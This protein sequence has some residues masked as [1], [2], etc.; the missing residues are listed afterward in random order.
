MKI[1]LQ[2]FQS[3]LVCLSYI[4][5]RDKHLICYADNNLNSSIYLIRFAND[6]N[7][8]Y[9][10]VYLTPHKSVKKMLESEGISCEMH[11]SLKGIFHAFRANI[12]VIS[13]SKGQ[14]NSKLSRHAKIIN[15]WHGISIKNIGALEFKNEK[16]RRQKLEKYASFRYVPSTSPFTQSCFMKAFGKNENQTP[17]L[18]E[19]RNDLLVRTIK[20]TDRTKL[21]KYVDVDLASISK[22]ISYMPTWRDYGDWDSN[23]DFRILNEKMINANALFL[24]KPHPKDK[25]LN[26]IKEFSN[27]RVVRRNDD[28]Q[29]AYEILIAT[30]ILITDYSSLAYEFI[31]TRRPI[32]LYTPDLENFRSQRDFW[33]DFL[34]MAPSEPITDLGKLIPQIIQLLEH[35]EVDERYL[36]TLDL[37]HSVQDGTSSQRVYDLIKSIS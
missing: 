11:K 10:H 12:Y 30:D 27:V 16:H 29:D 28:W 37:L 21:S 26:S 15:L 34:E 17:I 24:V 35:P 22:I 32:I 5:P 31:L 18:G 6:Q 36:Q 7:D 13:S 19:P 2:V 1:L 14:V 8:Q 4:V 3:V 23:I 25:S 9:K 20:K 33:V